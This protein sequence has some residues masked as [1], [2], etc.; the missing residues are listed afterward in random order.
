MSKLFVKTNKNAKDFESRNATL[1]IKA[2]FI[3]QTM[4]GVFTFLPLGTRVLYK[5]EAIVREEMDKI[6]VEV[7]MPS[8]VPKVL[9][10]TTA[11]I[12]TVD[13]LMKTSPANDYAKAK[14]DAEYVLSSTHEEVI[15]PLVQ[16][17]AG[18]YKDLPVAAYQIQTKF[19]NEP[20]AK[21]GLL[22]CREFRMKD[23][24]SFHSSEEDLKR[25]YEEV[26]LA[27]LR[28]FD[29]LGLGEDTMVVLASGGDFT[30]EYSHEF[31]TRC[32]TGEDLVFYAKNTGIAYNREVAP[33]FAPPMD[34]SAEEMKE[35]KEVEGAGI[36]GVDELASYLSIPVEKT[37]KTILFETDT[38]DVI[39]A[40][41]RGGGYEINAEKLQKIS[42]YKSVRMAGADTVK[43]VTGAEIGYAGILNLPNDV[44]VFYDESLKGR[45]NFETGANRT[46]YHTINVNF[47][48]DIPEPEEFYD[49]KTAKEGDRYPGT[50]E[51]YEV[52]KGSEVGNIFP[53]NT[54]FSKAFG[55]T[56]KDET[57]ADKP[58]Y[59][60]CYGIGTS[61]LMGVIAEK[62]SDEKGLSWPEAVSPFRVHLISLPGG[63]ERAHTVY[64]E[65][66]NNGIDVLWDDRAES[67]GVKFTDA[68]LIGIPVRLVVSKKT[69]DQLEW[70]LRAQK[71][72]ELI[73]IEEVRKRLRVP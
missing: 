22:R 62:F 58:V 54:K 60:G 7:F 64:E 23:L 27:Y 19:R 26:K 42:G 4:A 16:K 25:Y 43:K 39:A 68:D 72:T 13:V 18:S 49:I 44:K 6:A 32:D 40:A 31:Q 63:E 35:K 67:A 3:D 15:T 50:G 73:D 69:G 8:I 56:F 48:R 2:G 37:T 38:G 41:V 29:R 65:L 59:M 28:L 52:F 34:D 53:L 1:L 30:K 14:H 5:I 10:E 57:G 17:F 46:N 45:K 9:W 12:H 55:Y 24:Y 70:K 33:S 21:S 20:R 36:V 51:E 71:E 11:R 47:G 61:R 66:E